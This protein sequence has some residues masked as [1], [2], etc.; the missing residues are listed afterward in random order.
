MRVDVGKLSNVIVP[1]VEKILII[2]SFVILFF[3]LFVG[4]PM[5]LHPGFLTGWKKAIGAGVCV[6]GLA[7]GMIGFFLLEFWEV[8]M[9]LDRLERELKAVKDQLASEEKQPEA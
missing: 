8:N 6:Y 9:K 5:V 2:V 7:C 1:K 3:T 4:V